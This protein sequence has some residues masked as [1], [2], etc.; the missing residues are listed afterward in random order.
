MF[1]PF[2]LAQP[3]VECGDQVQYTYKQQLGHL[4]QLVCN[5]GSTD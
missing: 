1:L 2:G 3:W 5:D 4:W